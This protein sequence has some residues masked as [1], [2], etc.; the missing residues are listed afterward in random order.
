MY[1]YNRVVKLS[2]HKEVKTVEREREREAFY[3]T[4]NLFVSNL[5]ED[6]KTREDWNFTTFI[7]P[8]FFFFPFVILNKETCVALFF[9][10]VSSQCFLQIL[11]E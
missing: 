7:S 8:C 11:S 6:K 9:F 4:L 1:N 5:M 3:K 2:G 10:F